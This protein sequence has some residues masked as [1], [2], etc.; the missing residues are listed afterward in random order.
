MQSDASI[1]S[2]ESNYGI[3]YYN[4]KRKAKEISKYLILFVCVCVC[5]VFKTYTDLRNK[6]EL[7]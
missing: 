7:N 1:V 5:C 4:T 3:W 6:I 2:A